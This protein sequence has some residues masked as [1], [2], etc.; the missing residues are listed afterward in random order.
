MRQLEQVGEGTYR[1]D[2]GIEEDDLGVLGET[3]NMQFC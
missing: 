3:E 2:V 1:E